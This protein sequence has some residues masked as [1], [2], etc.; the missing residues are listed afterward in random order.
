MKIKNNT[1]VPETA[2]EAVE[3]LQTFFQADMWYAK[4][5]EWKTEEDM[6]N[7]LDAHFDICKKSI[8]KLK[9]ENKK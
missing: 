7:Y 8:K 2:L 4:G 6:L 9:M 3:F 1:C 5:A